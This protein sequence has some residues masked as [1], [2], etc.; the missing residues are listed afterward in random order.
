MQSMNVKMKLYVQHVQMYVRKKIHRNCQC[1][2][3][4]NIISNVG[5]N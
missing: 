4:T 3:C 2:Y 5:V 1:N